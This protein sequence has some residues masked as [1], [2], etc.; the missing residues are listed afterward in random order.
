MSVT[1]TSHAVEAAAG[2]GA[3]PRSAVHWFELFADDLSRA[4]TF[5]ETLY[6]RPL[7]V[8]AMGGPE[9]VMFPRGEGGVGGCLMQRP[10]GLERGCNAI[11]Y[12]DADP[13]LDALL[14]RVPAAGG[15]VLVP[16]TEL[17][18]GLGVFAQ[19]IDS[20]GQVVGLHAAR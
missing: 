17:P 10:A 1:T 3:A 6:D 20:E 18:N 11:V 4:R 2:K 14:A 15:R 12:L 9:M 19:V 7:E 8:V 13:S 16:R 5:Y